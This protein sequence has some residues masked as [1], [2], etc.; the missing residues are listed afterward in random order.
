MLELL[1]RIFLFFANTHRNSKATYL[2][3]FRK[4]MMTTEHESRNTEPERDKEIHRESEK[5]RDKEQMNEGA[6]VQ[7]Q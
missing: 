7:Q 5:D 3:R 6:R 2:K 1:L 4:S